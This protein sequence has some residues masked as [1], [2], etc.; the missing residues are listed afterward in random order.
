MRHASKSPR[1][2]E[3][4]STA[5]G[6][7]RRQDLLDAGFTLIAE[8]GFEGLRTRDIAARAGLNVAML[9]YYFGSKDALLTALADHVRDTF[10]APRRPRRSA[11]AKSAS[12]L[13]SDFTESWRVLRSNP[14]LTTILIEMSLRARRDP[15]A[16]KALRGVLAS[17]TQRIEELLRR[18]LDAGE[19]RADLDPRAAAVVVT[20]F[21][22][23]ASL[24]LG[25]NPRAF[26]AKTVSAALERWFAA[27]PNTSTSSNRRRHRSTPPAPA[28]R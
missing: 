16:R 18:G 28:R 23:G 4:L 3:N 22:I 25:V 8:K 17:W 24:Q 7:R 20:S 13:Q 19:L 14:H 6:D 10:N 2:V 15:A 9:H 5:R 26:D 11:R 21:F 1:K 12:V 27:P